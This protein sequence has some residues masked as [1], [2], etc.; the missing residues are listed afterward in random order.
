MAR[1]SGG[2]GNGDTCPLFQDHGHMVVLASGRQYCS[3]VGHEGR[4][5]HDG[6]PATLPTP[7]FWPG[8]HDS[9]PAAIA[10]YEEAQR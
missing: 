5:E 4:P 3:H 8:G 6:K 7:A 1:T 10:K 2:P 9:F